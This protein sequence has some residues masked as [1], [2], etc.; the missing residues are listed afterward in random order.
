MS[1]I[2]QEIEKLRMTRK[3]PDSNPATPWWCR[4]R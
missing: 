4:S 2:I 3:V 1:K